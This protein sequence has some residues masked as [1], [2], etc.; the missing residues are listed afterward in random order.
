MAF[1]ADFS[2]L[3]NDWRATYD[4]W[5]WSSDRLGRLHLYAASAALVLGPLIFLR[6][7]GDLTH[8]LGGLGY[9]FA[10]FT[11]NVTALQIYDFTGGPNFFHVAALASLA[12]AIAGLLSIV[13]YGHTKQTRALEAHIDLMS[14]SYFGL[15][16]AAIAESWTRGLGPQLDSLR[17]FWIAFAISMVVAGGVGAVITAKLTASVKRRWTAPAQAENAGHR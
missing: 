6:A 3:E 5:T 2:G 14:W 11:T 10:M 1:P 4:F 12:T 16:L 13:V 9:V 17:T 8:R 7:K 15:V